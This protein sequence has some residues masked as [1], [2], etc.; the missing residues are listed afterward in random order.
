MDE[1]NNSYNKT[2][3]YSS[4]FKEIWSD[5]RQVC[6]CYGF[7]LLSFDT[8]AERRNFTKIYTDNYSKIAIDNLIGAVTSVSADFSSY[9]WVTT[10]KLIN[11]QL[12]YIPYHPTAGARDKPC[13]AVHKL[14]TK[15]FGFVEYQCNFI[16]T[17]FFCEKKAFNRF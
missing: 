13:L 5:A 7:D 2:Y 17:N 6:K 11:F 8:E 10:G 3:Y 1:L 16:P 9:T 15:T 14:T 12:D 4:H